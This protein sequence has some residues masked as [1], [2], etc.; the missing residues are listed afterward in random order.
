LLLCDFI[1]YGDEYED[2]MTQAS[3]QNEIASSQVEE[4]EKEVQVLDQ[5][6]EE[7]INKEIARYKEEGLL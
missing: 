1:E 2:P 3:I 7:E 5:A 6:Q 4:A